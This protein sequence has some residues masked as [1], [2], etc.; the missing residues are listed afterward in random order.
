M[1]Q[2]V[3]MN[4]Y[5]DGT[6]S[7]NS[8]AFPWSMSSSRNLG[9]SPVDE[10]R[11][12]KNETISIADSCGQPDMSGDPFTDQNYPAGCLWGHENHN[13]SIQGP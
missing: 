13:H 1:I 5:D 8:S 11:E 9:I 10:K 7:D 2:T 4:V 3:Q 12:A 6:V